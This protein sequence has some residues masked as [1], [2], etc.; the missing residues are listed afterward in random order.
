MSDALV[1]ALASPD[2]PEKALA[3][4]RA[5]FEEEGVPLRIERADGKRHDLGRA[6]ARSALLGIGLGLDG[7]SACTV[8]AGA[9]SAAYLEATLDDVRA[10][11]HDAARIAGRRPLRRPAINESG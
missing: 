5:G 6:A 1:L 11:A 3:D 7:D 2:V 8:L 10:M 9:P 4:L